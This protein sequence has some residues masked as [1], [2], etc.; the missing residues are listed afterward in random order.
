L[1]VLARQAKHPHELKVPEIPAVGNSP[2]VSPIASAEVPEGADFRAAD[3]SATASRARDPLESEDWSFAHLRRAETLW[4]PHGYHRYPAKFIPQLV[5]RVIECYSTTGSLVG[6]PFLGSATTGIEALR[7][8]R[9]FWGSE[10]NPVALLISQAKC[11]PIEPRELDATWKQLEGQLR[12]VPRIGRRQLTSNE[13]SAI[14]AID[15][16]RASRPERFAYWFPAAWVEPLEQLLAEIMALPHAAKRTFFL[17]G[18]SNVLRRCSIWLSGSTKPQKDLTKW[19]SDPLEAFTGQA[20]DMMRRNRLYW[21][22]LQ[23]H[24]GDSTV[25]SSRFHLALADAKSLPLLD[26]VLD[27]VVTSPPYATCYE[28]LELYQLTQ[29]WFEPRSILPPNNLS[30]V[31]IGG[32]KVASRHQDSFAPEVSTGSPT[33]DAALQALQ[34][35]ATGNVAADVVREARALRYYFQDM[36]VVLQELARVTSPGGHIVLVVGDSYRRGVTIPTAISLCEMAHTVGLQEERR[37]RRKVPV[38]VLVSTRDKKTGR[39]SS[40]AHSDTRVYPEEEI[41][42]FARPRS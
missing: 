8:G 16:T 21:E 14:E 22:D 42:V 34:V 40:T 7:T 13:R 18:F 38:R 2:A 23:R 27:L 29:L 25:V 35:G 41:L 6:D 4:G 1:T 26:G 12:A 19:L 11:S 24:V 9:R 30:Q 20:R 5:R 33:A 3:P 37:I 36:R 32:R 31:W 10:I 39:F 15:I 17:C 28:Y